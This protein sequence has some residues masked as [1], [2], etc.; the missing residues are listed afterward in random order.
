MTSSDEPRQNVRVGEELDLAAVD[1]WLRTQ[2]PHLAGMP[3]VSQYAGGA[4]NW[5]YRL[6]YENEDLVLRRP[7]AGTKARSAHDMR[8]EFAIQSALAPHFPLVPRMRALCTDPGVIGCD[9]YVMD[10][11]DGIVPG[12]QL[13]RD[14]QLT[15]AENRKLCL[16]TI[17]ALVALHGVDY[18]SAGLESIGSGSGYVRRQIEGWTRRYAEA[19][20][21]NVPRAT[22]ITSWLEKNIPD[23]ERLCVIHND[24]RFD[25]LVL[26]RRDPLEIIGVLDWEMATIG[27]PLMDLG[28][29]L[30]YWVEADDDPIAQAT[31]RQPTNLPGM[32]T[33]REV[34]DYYSERTGI[35]PASWAF[36]E[37]Y[38]LFRLSVIAQQIY[39]RYH[40]RQTRNR[41]FRH[42][43]F[44]VHYLQH[45]CR[46]TMRSE[47]R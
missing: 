19:R 7:P 18:R 30:A 17:D 35:R 25:N 29:T 12:R 43:W 1:R 27:D 23:E 2:L 32:L 34:T 6:E 40:H 37:V 14:V 44:F 15:P 46:M 20:T 36:Y 41:A 28:N 45:R 21:W 5:T 3:R 24:F 33:R 9:F 47:G 22:G 13:G 10:R 8:R 16:N 39:F 38:G 31:R 26:D 42:F 4:S 11:L